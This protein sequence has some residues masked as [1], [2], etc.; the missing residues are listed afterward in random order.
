MVADEVKYVIQING[1]LR[2]EIN[3]PAE[4]PKSEIEAAAL[5]NLTHSDL[6]TANLSVRSLLCQRNWST[7]W[8]DKA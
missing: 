4:T 3:V 5:A 7:L 6:L 1:K 8:S 2:G